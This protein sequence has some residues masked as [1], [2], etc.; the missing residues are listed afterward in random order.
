[1]KPGDLNLADP[2]LFQAGQPFEYDDVL[3]REAPVHWN[4]APLPHFQMPMCGK[5]L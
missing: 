2:D 1:M 5:R 4:P 3:R